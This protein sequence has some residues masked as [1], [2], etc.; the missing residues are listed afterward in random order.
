MAISVTI[1]GFGMTDKGMYRPRNED[2][3]L[4]DEGKSLYLL[5]DGMGGHKAGE[6]ASVGACRLFDNFFDPSSPHIAEHFRTVFEKTN[7]I[8]FEQASKR[9]DLAGMGAT[10]IACHAAG[11]AAYILHAGDVRAYLRRRGAIK[12]LTEDHSLVA[13]LVRSGH[14]TPEQAAVHPMKSQVTKAIGIRE[15]ITPGFAG[16][17]LEVEDI[18][19][20]CS[21]GLWGTVREEKIGSALDPGMDLDEMAAALVAEANRAGGKDN[22]T[23]V[24]I[25]CTDGGEN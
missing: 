12:R 8:L 16:V 1:K 23:V 13:E 9:E 21:D 5:A 22:I 25:G 4:I 6:V 11:K 18:L 7:R 3:F 10:F 19:L 14:L 17:D 15:A 24:L 2:F 20:L